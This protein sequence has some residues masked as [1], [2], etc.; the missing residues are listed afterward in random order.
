[1]ENVK[2][3][4]EMSTFA[5]RVSSVIESPP[6]RRVSTFLQCNA[7]NAL[8]SLHSL[9]HCITLHYTGLSIELHCMCIVL[10]CIGFAVFGGVQSRRG[11]PAGVGGVGAG[12]G[13]G[14]GG[15]IFFLHSHILAASLFIWAGIGPS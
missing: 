15:P 14:E 4:V 7:C 2:F 6:I 13:G 12:D 9:Q 5:E 1:M 11:G 3:L 10:H 8:H